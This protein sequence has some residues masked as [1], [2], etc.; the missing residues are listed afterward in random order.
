MKARRL[1]VARG[2]HRVAP[3]QPMLWFTSTG[4]FAKV[5]SAGNRAVL[6][7]LD[8]PLSRPRTAS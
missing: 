8:L 4:S 2:D 1:A 6:Q 3:N 7:E 5:L